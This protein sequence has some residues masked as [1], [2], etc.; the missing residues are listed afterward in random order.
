[1][2]QVIQAVSTKGEGSHP[3]ACQNRRHPAGKGRVCM[4]AF[5][6]GMGTHP[7][8]LSTTP[9]AA[10]TPEA[11]RTP[12]RMASCGRTVLTTPSRNRSIRSASNTMPHPRLKLNAGRTNCDGIVAEIGL[13]FTD[14]GGVFGLYQLGLNTLFHRLR[15]W[16][17]RVL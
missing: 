5:V 14:F 2:L 4:A 9:W 13:V 10:F 3:T 12:L 8:R 6:S 15:Y 16:K 11:G 7:R 17:I 1:M